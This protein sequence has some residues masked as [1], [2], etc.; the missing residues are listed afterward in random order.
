MA[1]SPEMTASVPICRKHKAPLG[2]YCVEM[3]ELACEGCK[4]ASGRKKYRFWTLREAAEEHKVVLRIS[5][6][7]LLA[8]VKGHEKAQRLFSDMAKHL[9][10]QAQQT[11]RQIKDEFEILHRFLRE[12]EEARIAALKEEE[13]QKR[14]T[15][16]ERIQGITEEM[17]YVSDTIKT[18]EQ[19]LEADDISFLQNYKDTVYKTWQ[20]LQDQRCQPGVYKLMSKVSEMMKLPGQVHAD[21]VQ[22]MCKPHPEPEPITG[23][24]IDV[25][26][27]LGNLK[28]RVWEK[29]LAIAP[30]SPVS[31]DPN[32]ATCRL[33]LSEG[34][35]SLKYCTDNPQLPDNP[36]RFTSRAEMLG[37]RGFASGTHHWDVDVG[38]NTSWAVGV[39]TQSVLRKGRNRG[40]GIV[41]LR[42]DNG[43][44][45]VKTAH[46]PEQGRLR[47]VRVELDWNNGR[48][49]F[50]DPVRNRPVADVGFPF[51]EPAFPYFYSSC[52]DHPLQIVPEKV[53][54]TVGA[55]KQGESSALPGIYH[56]FW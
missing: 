41:A 10:S 35:T 9:K 13:E 5:R 1:A 4:E 6:D 23:G 17:S 18:I 40:V 16:K 55:P 27:H 11:E 20:S 53:S 39:A 31:L 54:I 21:T 14:R 38:D 15:L 42:L 46:L 12:E 50:S 22:R 45:R 25:A 3:E 44:Y 2:L 8:K 28:Y 47:R 36:E 43:S 34:L 52:E 48:V 56:W 30:Y 33:S 26:K 51:T 29:M 32:T 37:S 24:L 19:E 49:T 7:K